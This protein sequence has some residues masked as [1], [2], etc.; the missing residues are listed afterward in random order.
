MCRGHFKTVSSFSLSFS[1]SLPLSSLPPFLLLS[2]LLHSMLSSFL[3]YLFFISP[4]PSPSP[5]PREEDTTVSMYPGLGSLAEKVRE[6][7]METKKEGQE[8]GEGG[9]EQLETK[10]DTVCEAVRKALVELG[11]NKL[12]WLFWISL[13]LPHSFSFS[14]PPP[15]P[16]LSLFLSIWP[17]PVAIVSLNSSVSLFQVPAL[18]DHIPCQEI[19]T[20][21]GDSSA[22]N[23]TLER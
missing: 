22:Q 15:S 16:L 1:P 21:I 19:C 13:P 5:P 11:E 23:Q 8:E 4:T 6:E 20:R 18:C 2:F 14:V 9:K 7:S 3:L 10:V 12:V 17:L